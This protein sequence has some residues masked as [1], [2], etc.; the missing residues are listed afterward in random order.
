MDM[1]PV[2][3]LFGRRILVTRPAAQ[4]GQ[5]AAM[6]REHGGEA[7]LFPCLEVACLPQAIRGAAALLTDPTV[8]IAFTSANGVHCVA[9]ALLPAER[10]LLGRHR[11]AAV[12]EKTA[13]AM[14]DH[15][16]QA[17][18]IAATASQDGLIEA[19]QHH[20]LPGRLLLF[21]AEEGRDTLPDWLQRQGVDVTTVHAYRTVCP[22]ADASAVI[23]DLRRGAI[24]AVLLGSPKTAAHYL[25]RIGDAALAA[26]PVL[27]AI[28]P[29]VARAAERLGLGVQVVAGTASF[30]SMLDALAQHYQTSTE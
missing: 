6:I 20:N 1:P 21:R 27:V 29:D 18:I 11:L 16:W 19:Y 13:Q 9:E 2:S 14:A 28:S 3:T 22:D 8:D 26:R 4:A 17:S 25:R 23:A 12:G 24:D 15:G 7:V 5:T 30:S 10:T